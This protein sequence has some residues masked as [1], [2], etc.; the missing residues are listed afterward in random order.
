M[1]PTSSTDSLNPTER[2][3]ALGL[4]GIYGLRMLGLFLILPV[5]ALYAEQLEGATPLLTGIAIGIYGL[6]Q[7][8][9]Q[10]PFGMLSDK[11][12]R[13][14][15]IIGGL[16]IFAIGSLVAGMADDIVW[17]VIGR[18]LQGA[19]AIAA[20]IMALAADLTRESQ[21]TKAMALIGMTIGASFLVAM[22]AGPWLNG[23]IGVPG[24]FVFTA[25]AAVL[26]MLVI[27]FVIPT[28]AR[29][30]IH[31]DAEPV[32]A[33][34]K[35]VLRHPQLLRLDLGIF[36]LHLLL[37]ALFLVVPLALRDAGL[38][39]DQHSWLY[40]GVLVASIVGM[41]PMVILAERKKKM[42]LV[43][44]SAICLLGAAELLL[45]SANG[46]LW[47]MVLALWVF[48]LGFN[49]LEALLP[50][51]VSKL[52]PA[53]AKGTAMGFY[54]TSQFAGAFV[55]GLLGGWLHQSGGIDGVFLAAAG[56]TVIWLLAS[57]GIDPTGGLKNELLAVGRLSDDQAS[58]LT[59][60]L[61]QIPGVA[62]AVVVIE[63][64]VAYLKV[65]KERL[66]QQ[67]LEALQ[68]IKA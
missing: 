42:R 38:A 65:D 68:P 60:E 25:I 37:T 22:I 6:T 31:R 54:S 59:R 9:L 66:D 28:P 14:P 35:K 44:L 56:L 8:M 50:S 34:F 12:G 17:I 2:R 4:A 62:E 21:R 48:F 63:E 1:S 39:P 52:A 43:F 30:S 13:K 58:L 10:I 15:V 20:A 36:S 64:E 51:L 11:W 33:L 24:I 57:W 46:A 29:S 41:V 53:A 7:A 40:L 45:F 49:L 3:A 18:A 61:L 47:L 16:A 23:L 26:G 27:A 32:P 55:G 5:F 19:G 67:A